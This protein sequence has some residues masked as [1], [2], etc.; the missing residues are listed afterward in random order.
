MGAKACRAVTY[1]AAAVSK[2][3][4]GAVISSAVIND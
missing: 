1:P 2:S 4:Q 3:A